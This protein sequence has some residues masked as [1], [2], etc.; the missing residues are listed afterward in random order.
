MARGQVTPEFFPGT[1]LDV[2]LEEEILVLDGRAIDAE[3]QVGDT[4]HPL[5]LRLAGV[6]TPKGYGFFRTNLPSRLGPRQV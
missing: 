4:T 3:V 1:D 2:L 6:H 5:P